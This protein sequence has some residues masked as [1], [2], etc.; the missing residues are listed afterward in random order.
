[1]QRVQKENGLLFSKK[2]NSIIFTG[3][4]IMKTSSRER[5]QKQYVFDPNEIVGM[6]IPHGVHE[7]SLLRFIE[8][9]QGKR[10]FTFESVCKETNHKVCCKLYFSEMLASGWQEEF[11]KPNRVQSDDIAYYIADGNWNFNNIHFCWIFYQWI[12]GVNLRKY[13][14]DHPDKF[15]INFVFELAQWILTPL[16]QFQQAKSSHGDIHM[17]NIMVTESNEGIVPVGR[18]SF[19]F[20]DFGISASLQGL[21]PRDDY[22]A[23]ATVLAKCLQQIKT[24]SLEEIF[25]KDKLAQYYLKLLMDTDVSVNALAKNPL[26]LHAVLLEIQIESSKSGEDKGS[27]IDFLKTPFELLSADRF[28][29]DS[30]LLR[31]LFSK[32][33]PGYDLL[34]SKETVIITGPRGCGKTMILR[35]LSLKTYLYDPKINIQNLPNYI[36]F[37][38]PAFELWSAFPKRRVDDEKSPDDIATDEFQKK[39]LHYFHLC[40]LEEVFSTLEQ[41]IRKFNK[42]KINWNN[43]NRI[44]EFINTNFRTLTVNPGTNLVSDVRATVEKWRVDYRRNPTVSLANENP[45]FLK[46]FCR[47]LNENIPIFK[48]KN[49]FF[50]LD[51]YSLGK[52]TPALQLSLNRIIF[53]RNPEFV[54]K[55]SAEKEAILLR[56]VDGPLAP[57]R[58]HF[59]IDIGYYFTNPEPTEERIKFLTEVFNNRLKWTK[60]I[61]YKK[62]EN[63]LGDTRYKNYKQFAEVLSGKYIAKKG[64][65]EVLRRPAYH[66]VIH[67]TEICSGDVAAIISLVQTIKIE[68]DFNLNKSGQKPIDPKKQDAAIKNYSRIFLEQVGGEQKYSGNVRSI[69][70]SFGEMAKWKLLNQPSRNEGLN[71]PF[72]AS[73]L[74]VY[75][76]LTMD[77]P[78][79]ELYRYLL[80]Y[81]IF[82]QEPRGFGQG[83]TTSRRL[84]FRR[85]FLPSFGLSFSRRDCIRLHMKDFIYL[86]TNPHQAK[87]DFISRWI[88]KLKN[89]H[90]KEHEQNLP[91]MEENDEFD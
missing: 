1:M 43:I 18:V 40:L 5:L 27:N 67:L 62:I 37:Y 33:I 10:G 49:I 55:I 87:D 88:N 52:I 66:G 65:D 12:N 75:E 58:T 26:K 78:T 19:K 9:E 76:D 86:L 68:G 89:E 48:N 6:T 84:Y 53:Q 50:L 91:G 7:Y 45:G 16:S 15:H 56:D 22:E 29:E 20:I 30:A 61:K 63:I 35:N 79:T 11:K 34:E 3:D 57:S 83:Q 23:T 51:D 54:F 71:T 31:E 70:K 17:G 85:L 59:E 77:L 14:R 21:Q 80:R 8:G 64:D 72:Q 82:I 4:N 60:D 2:E 42:E 13:I 36:G 47:C 41:F 39:T 73:R 25:L 28:R 38:L 81:G 46:D 44:F 24:V 69:A 74:E 90:K 32:A